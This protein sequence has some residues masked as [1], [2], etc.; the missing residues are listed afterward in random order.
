MGHKNL[1]TD[2]VLVF[3]IIDLG[4]DLD[5]DFGL[6]LD[7]CIFDTKWQKKQS[8]TNLNLRVNLSPF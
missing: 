2:L 8:N 5:M 4:K 1:M 7:N 3:P 6:G